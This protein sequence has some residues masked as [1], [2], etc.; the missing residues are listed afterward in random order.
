MAVRREH[1]VPYRAITGI[2][3][4]A[5]AIAFVGKMAAPTT[6]LIVAQATAELPAWLDVGGPVGAVLVTGYFLVTRLDRAVERIR[7]MADAERAELVKRAA[8][9][10]AEHKAERSQ[11]DALRLDQI[12]RMQQSHASVVTQLMEQAARDRAHL[13]DRLEDRFQQTVA[14]FTQ[15]LAAA[16]AARPAEN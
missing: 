12:E 11:L 15:H 9:E 14:I 2:I 3:E 16:P 7:E 5:D 13:S 4:H 6:A 1:A 8:E 10:R